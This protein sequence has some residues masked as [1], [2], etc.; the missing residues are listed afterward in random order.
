MASKKFS[1]NLDQVKIGDEFL[2]ADGIKRIIGKRALKKMKFFEKLYLN[3][4]AIWN[5]K[6]TGQFIEWIWN[7]DLAA[8]MIDI[9]EQERLK[10]Y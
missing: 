1:S 7:D 5:G 4:H 3:T 8:R 10:E 2:D 6:I 9:Y